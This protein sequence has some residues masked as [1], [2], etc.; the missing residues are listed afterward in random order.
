MGRKVDVG[1]LV[2]SAEAGERLG[3]KR[4]LVH[5]WLRRYPDFP[6]PIARL[7]IGL[8]WSWPDIE[9]WTAETGR[10]R[11]AVRRRRE[12]H[13]PA[14]RRRSLCGLSAS[15][16][17]IPPT[18]RGG[19][20]LVRILWPGPFAASLTAPISCLRSSAPLSTSSRGQASG[21]GPSS[22][23][24]TGNSDL[25]SLPPVRGRG[26]VIRR[27]TG[28]HPTRRAGAGRRKPAQA[29]TGAGWHLFAPRVSRLAGLVE[30]DQLV[31][32]PLLGDGPC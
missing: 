32:T 9:K 22:G 27:D 28:H 5:D 19:P 14:C 16:S 10:P 29:G 30:H 20:L 12:R 24:Q 3:V 31:I 7:A 1:D 18:S 4:S 8:V 23:W 26:L 11:R 2:S 25:K 6:R 13:A 17:S 15:T 21:M